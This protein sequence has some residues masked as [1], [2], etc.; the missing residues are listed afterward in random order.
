MSIKYIL[1]D[2]IENALEY[3]EF[4]M[5]E[6]GTFFGRITACKGVIATGNTLAETSRELKSV[7]EDWVLMGL[8]LGHDLPVING[9][10]L[11]INAMA[12]EYEA[13]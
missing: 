12:E 8:K 11:N 4:E 9:I 13:M 3:S 2:Y 7:L 5:L 6:D 10:D 1:S